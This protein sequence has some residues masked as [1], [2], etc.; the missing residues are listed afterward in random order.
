[1]KIAGYMGESIVDGPGLR[2]TVFTQGCPH[3]CPGCHNPQ[4]H[5]FE[6][7]QEVTISALLDQMNKNPL[8]DGLT[9]S[10][11]EPFMQAEACAELASAV[12][13]MGKNVWCYTGFIFE[14]LLKQPEYMAL[15]KTIDVLIDGPFILSERTLTKRWRG[16]NNQR[17]LDVKQ[18]LWQGVPVLYA[19]EYENTIKDK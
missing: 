8:L 16:S 2:F 3:A 1:M 15:L 19:K 5:C 13:K 17:I 18:S 10:G 4:T 7:G 14:D 11:G 12:K 9:L 6:G